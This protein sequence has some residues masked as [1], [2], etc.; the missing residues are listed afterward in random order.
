M[1]GPT[2]PTLTYIFQATYEDGSQY[3]QTVADV[4]T[5]DPKKSA[6]FDVDI[7]K[8]HSFGLI[9]P[10]DVWAVDLIDGHFEHNGVPFRLYQYDL[11]HPL[12]LVFFRYAQVHSTFAA[13]IGDDLTPDL[14]KELKR[15]HYYAGYEIGWESEDNKGN[16]L[17]YTITV[18]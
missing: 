14:S 18:V 1:V 11:I 8:L 5:T 2:T 13:T 12:R 3:T 4:S 6:F 10:S 15:E 7:A 9:G 17:K 16:P